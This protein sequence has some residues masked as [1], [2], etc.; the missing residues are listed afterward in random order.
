VGGKT[1]ATFVD[2]FLL[3][4]T[5]VVV[6]LVLIKDAQALQND[7]KK[8]DFITK[9]LSTLFRCLPLRCGWLLEVA[10]T[11]LVTMKEIN[12]KHREK[13]LASFLL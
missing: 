1:S 6:T 9:K 10:N 11:A 13:P 4:F 7:L 3:L 5:R 8:D 12:F 2:S